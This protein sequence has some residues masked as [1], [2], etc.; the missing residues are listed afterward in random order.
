MPMCLIASKVASI[1]DL[2]REQ[3]AFGN[4][5]HAPH[6]GILLGVYTHAPFIFV[7]GPNWG[8]SQ[9]P[10][11]AAKAALVRSQALSPMRASQDKQAFMEVAVSSRSDRGHSIDHLSGFPSL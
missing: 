7:P 8:G 4:A 10:P 1:M 9:S 5:A 2:N 11:S 6:P 3:G